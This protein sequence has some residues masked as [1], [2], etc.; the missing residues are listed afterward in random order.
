MYQTYHCVLEV[1]L[2]VCYNQLIHKH[3][4]LSYRGLV[5]FPLLLD[6]DQHCPEM[7]SEVINYGQQ[8]HP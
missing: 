6:I 1:N 5:L 4:Q 7:T 8:D 3:S 2:K